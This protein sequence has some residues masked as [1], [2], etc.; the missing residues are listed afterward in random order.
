MNG[1]NAVLR[2]LAGSL[3]WVG[4]H[5]IAFTMW[6]IEDQN[7]QRERQNGSLARSQLLEQEQGQPDGR[8]RKELERLERALFEQSSTA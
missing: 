5:W 2:Q 8:K 7:K 4:K 3:W 6:A 1:E